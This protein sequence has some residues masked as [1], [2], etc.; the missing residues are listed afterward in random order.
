[1]AVI[2]RIQD[3]QTIR[4]TVLNGGTADE[5]PFIEYR[6]E[7]M[8]VQKAFK[9]AHFIYTAGKVKG[10]VVGCPVMDVDGDDVIL[11]FPCTCTI[12]MSKE[13]TPRQRTAPVDPLAME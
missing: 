13:R 6:H 5:V 9:F 10:V 7:S 4:D 11:T 8:P 2:L 12:D 1:M 3:R